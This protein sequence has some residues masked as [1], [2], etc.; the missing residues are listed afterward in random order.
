MSADNVSPRLPVNIIVN[1]QR[2]TEILSIQA[3][4]PQDAHRL[5]TQ[6]FTAVHVTDQSGKRQAGLLVVKEDRILLVL[7]EC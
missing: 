2:R 4:R 1:N 3:Q 7:G 6:I 5:S